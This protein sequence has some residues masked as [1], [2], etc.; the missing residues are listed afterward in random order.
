MIT[1]IFYG[2]LMDPEMLYRIVGRNPVET[3]A[4]NISGRLLQIH[5]DTEP[6]GVTSYPML[7]STPPQITIRAHLCTF[8]GETASIERAL[9]IYEGDRFHRTLWKFH[10]D[11][12]Q[13][14]Y[15]HIFIGTDKKGA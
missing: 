7:V 10:H 15:G 14:E 9:Q 11:D 3:I 12:G 2:S 6:N 8:D 4:G 13:C 5:D 1:Y